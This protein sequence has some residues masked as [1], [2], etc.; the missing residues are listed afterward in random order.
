MEPT[1]LGQQQLCFCDRCNKSSMFSAALLDDD[2]PLDCPRCGNAVSK[3]E[4]QSGQSVT[5]RPIRLEKASVG[6]GSIV[7]LREP[8]TNK[9]EVKRTIGLPNESLCVRDG[10]LWVDGRRFQKS[11]TQFLA[12]SIE[13]DAWNEV[14][15]RLHSTGNILKDE[16]C[17]HSQS[18]WPRRDAELR[19]HPSPILDEYR[20]NPAE[21]RLPVQVRDIGLKM[22]LE[23]LASISATIEIRIWVEDAVRSVQMILS[24]KGV[25]VQSSE[26]ENPNTNQVAASSRWKSQHSR[27]IVVAMV[28]GR[29]LVGT[30]RSAQSLSPADFI[31]DSKVAPLTACS[32]LTPIAMTVLEGSLSIKQAI[33]IRDIHYRGWQGEETFSL[34]ATEGYHLFGDNVS[35]SSDSRNRWPNG[36]PAEWILGRIR[37]D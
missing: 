6:R 25:N 37:Q 12:Q 20:S 14:E 32:V 1:L 23:D 31:L 30:D 4:L 17:F 19:P 33:V 5:V 24:E 9:L 10:D 13:V 15:T 21:S 29:M 26:Q 28:D 35:S 7:V 36:V 2:R 11:M 18:L 34:P 3:E 27:T 16:F 8:C 22:V